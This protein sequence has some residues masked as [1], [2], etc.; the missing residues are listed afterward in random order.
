MLLINDKHRLHGPF[1]REKL[2]AIIQNGRAEPAAYEVKQS[3]DVVRGDLVPVTPN[4]VLS[5]CRP[6]MGSGDESLCKPKS[7]WVRMVVKSLGLK[8][9][10]YLHFCD[11]V[12]V[13]GAEFMPSENVPYPIPDKRGDNAFITCSYLSD[14]SR[15][16]K[17]HPLMRL[18]EDLG[19]WGFRTAS[20]AASRDVVFPNGPLEWYE[21]R[22][23][24]DR[25]VLIREPLHQAEIHYLQ[26]E[27]R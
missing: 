1:S 6:C 14:E 16:Y 20:I 22:G 15:D 17:T 7:E 10:G 13:G 23:F 8:H 19:T 18:I 24:V 5:A 27:I 12:C 11:G 4:S 2:K 26:L 25:G 9:L 3:Q 21:K